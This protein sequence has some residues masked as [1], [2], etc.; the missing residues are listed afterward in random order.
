[1]PT[2]EEIKLRQ[3]IRNYIS[4]FIFAIVL[5]G[6]TTFPIET[7]L[8]WMNAHLDF[9]PEVFRG[10]LNQVYLAVKEVNAEHPFLSYGTD[11]LAFSPFPPFLPF[12]G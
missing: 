5:S 4:F 11:W 1:M 10:W 9:F 8:A 6:L 3:T 12:I 2:S 7:E